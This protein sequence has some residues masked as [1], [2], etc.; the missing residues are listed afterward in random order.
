MAATPQSRQTPTLSRKTEVIH[1]LLQ[2]K[3]LKDFTAEELVRLPLSVL[4]T[5]KRSIEKQDRDG[6]SPEALTAID[7]IL[8]DPKNFFSRSDLE[9][10]CDEDLLNEE[11]QLREKTRFAA[12]HSIIHILSL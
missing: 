9:L 8:R 2:N 7:F 10:M 5:E 11:A 1:Y 12:K 6:K 4:L 3:A